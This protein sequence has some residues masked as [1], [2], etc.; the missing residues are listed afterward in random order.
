ML[1]LVLRIALAL[2]VCCSFSGCIALAVGG[3]AGAAGAIYVK[4]QLKDHLNAPVERAY[5]ASVATLDAK[6][7]AI[8]SKSADSSSAHIKAK[9]ADGKEIWIDLDEVTSAVCDIHIRVGL[10]GDQ[11]R[12]IDLLDGIKSKL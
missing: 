12:S 3:A 2:L 6:K 5:K 1:N 9:Y 7:I 8:T 11:D 10:T 4:G